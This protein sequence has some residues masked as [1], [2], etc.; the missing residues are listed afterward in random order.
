MSNIETVTNLFKQ[1]EEEYLEKTVQIFESM[2]NVI[3]AIIKF[4]DI[5]KEHSEG[6]LVWEEVKLFD[7]VGEEGFVIMVGSIKYELGEKYELPTGEVIE[8]NESNI[9]YLQRWIRVGI[10]LNIAVEG[11]YEDVVEFLEAN[12]ESGGSIDAASLNQQI[13]SEQQSTLDQYK[14]EEFDLD[15]LSDE[16]RESL[17]IFSSIDGSE[18]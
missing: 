8:V 15:D 17:R 16:Q 12:S 18:N 4:L 7:E 5:E 6:R 9:D 11:S 14:D 13:V 3:E 2:P 1:R 10:P